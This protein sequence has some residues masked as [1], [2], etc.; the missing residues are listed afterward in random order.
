MNTITGTQ[1]SA[2]LNNAPATLKNGEDNW[3]SGYPHQWQNI[4]KEIQGSCAGAVMLEFPVFQKGFFDPNKRKKQQAPEGFRI[5]YTETDKEFCGV[6][7]HDGKAG[8][9]PVLAQKKNGK[10][11]AVAAKDG[12]LGQT[13]VGLF[14]LCT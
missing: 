8:T 1:I 12:T 6:I 11:P 2:A 4:G 9:A 3:G 5:I 13:S 10:K 7:S 14:H